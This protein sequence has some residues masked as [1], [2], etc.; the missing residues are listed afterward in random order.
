VARLRQ[1]L[2]GRSGGPL[3]HR[4][5]TTPRD[6]TCLLSSPAAPALAGQRR[7]RA[8]APA[9]R[10]AAGRQF[11]DGLPPDGWWRGARSHVAPSRGG[12][13]VAGLELAQA[14]TLALDQ[15]APW[16]SIR[17]S[18]GMT[19]TAALDDSRPL[20]WGLRMACPS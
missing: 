16:T 8:Y 1:T 19:I 11:A 9:A 17:C 2:G 20:A 12:S 5:Y 3:T 18:T 4:S 10:R 7:D 15:N 6:T 14:G 13:L